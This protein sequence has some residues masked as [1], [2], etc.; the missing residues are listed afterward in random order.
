MTVAV[1]NKS[2]VV[3]PA[4]A[5]RRAGFKRGQELEVKSASGVITIV[6]RVADEYTVQE[7]RALNRGINQSLKEYRE[8][9][10]AGPFDTA[11]EF[12]ADLHRESARLG[13][14]KNKRARK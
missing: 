3:V 11:E 4:A 5:L 10:G 7:R 2:P 13:T 1:K 12:L 8:G 14:K 6:P 9:K